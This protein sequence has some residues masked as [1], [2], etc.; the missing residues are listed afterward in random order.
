VKPTPSHEALVALGMPILF[1]TNYDELIEDAHRVAGLD[2]RVSATEDE[3]KA[4]LRE[5][6]PYHLVKLHGSIDRP[7]TIVLTRDDYSRARKA[8]REMLGHLR[9]EMARASFLFVGFSLSDP[10]FNLLRDDIRVTGDRNTP[11]L[12]S[13]R[14]TRSH[15]GALS[16][17]A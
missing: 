1:T 5:E 4:R 11:K 16:V 8:R 15:Q 17:I 14:A 3:F 2:V 13:S 7:Q 12:Y 10:N 6:P 9:Q